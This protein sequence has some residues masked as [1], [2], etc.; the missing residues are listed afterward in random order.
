MS[1]GT[2]NIQK[3]PSNLTL[4]GPSIWLDH[5]QAHEPVPTCLLTV[6]LSSRCHACYCMPASASVLHHSHAVSIAVLFG[7]LLY[8]RMFVDHICTVCKSIHSLFVCKKFLFIYRIILCRHRQY[9]FSS[10]MLFNSV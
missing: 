1:G 7:I 10:N 4:D 5:A 3:S 2:I 9:I 8:L 6:R